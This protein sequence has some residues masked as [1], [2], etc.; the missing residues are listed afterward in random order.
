VTI[1]RFIAAKRA[2][3]SIL[4]MCRVLE[5][6]RS[7]FHAWAAR[8]PSARAVADAALTGRI[9][10]IHK[11]SLKTYGSPRV[12]AELR[13]ED[14]V[15][16][17]KKRVERL[18]RRAGLSGQVKRRR[19]KTT[20]RVQ[21]VRT[22]PDLVERDFNPTEPNRLWAADITYIRTWEGWLYLASVMDLYSRRIVGWAMADH[23]R[24]ELVVDALE[25]AV[26]RRR[27]D[28]G[29]VHHSDQGS[30]YTSL[31][32]TRRCRSVGID[33]SM[34][35]RGDCFDNAV[36]ESFHA[37][38]KKDL[39]HRRSWPTKAEARTAVFGYVETFYNRR[40]RHST[41]GMLS[42]VEFETSTLRTDG[43]SLAASRLAS[44]NKM[45]YKS[46]STAQA[47]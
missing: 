40:R 6:S 29:L 27:P 32:F 3:H 7:G 9:A 4:I 44:T 31:I 5:V 47:A 12:H 13:L 26:S 38:L 24:A 25:M 35:S 1:F 16:V 41:L 37:S 28:A 46:T 22:A 21:G 19:G 23:L 20:I 45:E 2:E 14:G 39:I 17:G 43:A 10:E 33:V 36:L 42:P 8:E 18:M 34:G 30:Q 15:R 11:G